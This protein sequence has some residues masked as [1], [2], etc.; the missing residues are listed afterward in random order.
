MKLGFSDYTTNYV[1]LVAAF[2]SFSKTLIISPK[3][4]GPQAAGSV[5]Q[6]LMSDNLGHRN[7]PSLAQAN[8][9]P[10]NAPG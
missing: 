3:T 10:H 4:C 7:Y 6:A 1:W 8:A 5:W 9:H 2:V